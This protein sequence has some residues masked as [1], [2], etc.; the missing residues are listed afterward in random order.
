[1]L[2]LIA[3][4][5]QYLDCIGVEFDEQTLTALELECLNNMPVVAKIN[6]RPWYMTS[7]ISVTWNEIKD[8]LKNATV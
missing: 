5:D 6:G 1:M 2:T 7:D 3:R 8:G 4:P